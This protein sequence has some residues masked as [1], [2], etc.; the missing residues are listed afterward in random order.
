MTQEWQQTQMRMRRKQHSTLCQVR[1]LKGAKTPLG[2]TMYSRSRRG[3]WIR[4]EWD[5]KPNLQLDKGR[6]LPTHAKPCT[7]GIL[8]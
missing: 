2:S 5:L 4:L 1:A 7:A 8:L 6:V 3:C